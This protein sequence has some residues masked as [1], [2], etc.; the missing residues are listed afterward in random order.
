MIL[1]TSC[2]GFG[3]HFGRPVLI[4][5][6]VTVIELTCQLCEGT[7]KIPDEKIEW[8]IQGQQLRKYR[9]Q[10]DISLRSAAKMLNIDASNL[11]KMERG[12]IKPHNIWLLNRN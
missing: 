6:K 9:L 1:C 8:V 5:G 3:K 4:K 10:Q 11:S 2:D 12:I 7:G